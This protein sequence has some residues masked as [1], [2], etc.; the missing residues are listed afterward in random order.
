LWSIGEAISGASP[1]TF[2]PLGAGV[3]QA[4]KGAG[5]L[6]DDLVEQAAARVSS[7]VKSDASIRSQLTIRDQYAHHKEMTDDLKAQLRS[8]GYRV[9]DEELSFGSSCGVGRCRSDIVYVGPDGKWGII[10][11]KTGNA[12]LT[13]RQSEIFPQIKDASAI[14]TVGIAARFGL[15]PGVPPKD[16]GYPNGI[17]IVVDR[18]R[19]AGQ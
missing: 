15:K 5:G 11:V 12:D 2:L 13:I 8:K 9:S 14:P 6:L 18:F 3:V 17:P 16:Q 19:G 4:T 10:E 1:G 7:R